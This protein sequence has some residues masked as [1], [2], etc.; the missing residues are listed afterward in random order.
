M[1]CRSVSILNRGVYSQ[2]C[3]FRYSL[4]RCWNSGLAKLLFVMHNPS[5][6]SEVLND[7]T[8]MACQNIGWLIGHPDDRNGV[9][10]ELIQQLPCFGSIRI[11]N[12]YP[13]FATSPREM[14]IPPLPVLCE[15]DREIKRACRWADWVICAW[16]VPKSVA[17]ERC[18][19][20]VIRA[21]KDLDRILCFGITKFGK[22]MHPIGVKNLS[23]GNSQNHRPIEE[24]M[25]LHLRCW[26]EFD[27]MKKVR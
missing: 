17:R 18:V 10:T 25:L 4:I 24:K 13:A 2:D 11:C 19:K 1:L 23:C 9:S 16:G 22:P 6:A 3:T 12:I 20:E 15:N 26:T 8:V 27:S 5:K 14:E 21:E 7:E